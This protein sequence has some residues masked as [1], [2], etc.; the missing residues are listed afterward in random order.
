MNVKEWISEKEFS[1]H[2]TETLI[3]LIFSSSIIMMT[4][5]IP[6]IK[7]Y[8]PQPFVHFLLFG[9][10]E[11]IIVSYW[12]YNRF[13]FPRKNTSKLNIV[14]AILTEN[15]K[16]KSR[17]REDFANQIQKRL[18]DLGLDN[19]HEII[20]LHN[21]LSKLTQ[22]RIHLYF[23]SLKANILNSENVHRFNQL[24]K[25][26]NAKLIIY[27]DLI[28]RN[29]N[30]STYCLNLDATLLHSPTDKINGNE[31]HNEFIALWKREITF[32]EQEELTG[33]KVNAEHIFFTASYMIGLATFA[34]NN[35]VEG[36][37]I[38][39]A[40][41]FYLKDKPDLSTYKEKVFKLNA[42]A[43]LLQS[44]LLYF[45]GE[46][47]GSLIYRNKYLSLIPNEYDKYLNEAIN[48]VMLRNDPELAL[49]FVNMASKVAPSNEGTW[50]YSKFY[51]LIKLSKCEEALSIFDEILKFKFPHEFDSINQV[52]VY[53]NKCLS[54]DPEHLQTYFIIGAIIFKKLN[55]P[56]EAY[57][58][59][60]LF[61]SSKEINKGW[62]PLKIRAEQYLKEIDE[63]IG[64]K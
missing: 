63:I 6:F 23:Q 45:K 5:V 27:G 60:E 15:A 51:L 54:D 57:E 55:L 20:V 13:V 53:N 48:Q 39:E 40:L 46:I 19:S 10:V 41:G 9:I 29:P 36:I 33:F 7:D 28:K 59:L 31:L 62:T 58:K 17:I 42:S 1:F 22:N 47:P 50:R 18:R 26:L 4:V 44:R 38:W 11:I 12:Y 2:R 49:D 52:I 21:N 37:K 61:V 32:L 56:I 8:S 24:M 30:N 35:F 64:V 25:R 43:Y 34:D 16:Q 3:F 14:I